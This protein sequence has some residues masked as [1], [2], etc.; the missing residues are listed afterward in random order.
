MSKLS[1]ITIEK[2]F[3]SDPGKRREWNEDDGCAHVF[4][5]HVEGGI[6]AFVAVSDGMGGKKRGEVASQEAL[7]VFQEFCHSRQG[8]SPEGD[9]ETFLDDL[10]TGLTDAIGEMNRR[11]L[12]QGMG[13]T[14][15]GVVIVGDTA[16]IGHVGDSRAYLIRDDLVDQ[17]TV[18]HAT[19]KGLLRSLGRNSETRP[20]VFDVEV[21]P[22]DGLL[23]CSDGLYRELTP[24]RENEEILLAV[25]GADTVNDTCIGL[26]QL[27]KR[28]G[29]RDNITVA[30][31]EFGKLS[32]DEARALRWKSLLDSAPPLDND[33]STKPAKAPTGGRPAAASSRRRPLILVVALALVLSA[34]GIVGVVLSRKSPAPAPITVSAEPAEEALET[35]PTPPAR[36]APPQ[37][38]LDVRPE[39]ADVEVSWPAIPEATHYRV[40]LIT[41]GGQQLLDHRMEATAETLRV[42]LQA[43]WADANEERLIAPGRYT[44]T[45]AAHKGS[46]LVPFAGGVGG[47]LR[48]P[49]GGR[50]SIAYE[51]DTRMQLVVQR[52]ERAIRM[53][54]RDRAETVRFWL[55]QSRSD[56]DS[57]RDGWESA[58]WV[59]GSR[60][61]I[62]LDEHGLE[63]V[64][65][66]IRAIF[67]SRRLSAWSAWSRPPDPPA[68]RPVVREAQRPS[69]R[70]SVSGEQRTTPQPAPR[71][72]ERQRTPDDLSF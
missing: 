31:L 21:R 51:Q 18:D 15:T 62:P 38:S 11:V 37:A 1:E 6:R 64:E 41:E 65:L 5:E 8:L 13:A 16:I 72:T 58:L 40:R 45:I 7:A 56:A 70:R 2:G 14:F 49:N 22:G 47:Y 29:G 10:R 44:V 36:P 63:N 17:K 20:D 71:P 60:S 25:H 54:W 59:P 24:E 46:G 66:R 39:T 26:V 52:D 9:L 61:S 35:P 53:N 68:E 42:D 67:A 3:Y 57:D 69:T 50:F 48:L 32:R 43:T 33:K 55:V 28:R 34:L 30:M 27:A 23:L 4:R 19:P 12:A